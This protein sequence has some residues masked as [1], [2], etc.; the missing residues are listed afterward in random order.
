[1]AVL[2]ATETRPPERIEVANDRSVVWFV[3]LGAVVLGMAAWIVYDLFFSAAAA[4]NG[5]LARVVNTYEL[6]WETGDLQTFAELT[7]GDYFFRSGGDQASAVVMRF[8]I[9]ALDGFRVEQQG[10]WVWSGEGPYHQV[11]IPQTV[12]TETGYP[13]PDG[14]VGMSTLEL[15]EEGDSYLV[16]SHVWVGPDR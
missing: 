13:G 15:V 16:A 5:E 7:T 2:E 4:P 3:V 1:M 9:G 6:A 10:R 11:S 12:F 8:R 14:I